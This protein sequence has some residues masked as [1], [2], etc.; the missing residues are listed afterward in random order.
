MQEVR[1]RR[2][3]SPQEPRYRPSHAQLLAVRRNRER[4]DPAR[5]EVGPARDRG[6]TQIVGDRRKRAQQLLDIGLIAGAA[7]T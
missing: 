5:H 6:E 3:E 7:A 4:L 1:K 2:T